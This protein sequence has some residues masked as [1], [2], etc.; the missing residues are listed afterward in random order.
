MNYHNNVVAVVVVV[1]IDIDGDV[2]DDDDSKDNK[3]QC[4]R[5]GDGVVAGFYFIHTMVPPHM[6]ILKVLPP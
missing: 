2:D 3:W 6:D 4:S 5:L 1:D